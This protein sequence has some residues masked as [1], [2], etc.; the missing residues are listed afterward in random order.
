MTFTQMTTNKWD[1]STPFK[2]LP[3]VEPVN[4]LEVNEAFIT[5]DIERHMQAYN[6]LL[7]SPTAH[8]GDDI[9]LSLEMHHPQTYCNWKKT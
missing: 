8:T 1:F 4:S 9:K 6:T 3:S 2:P 5:P 7:D